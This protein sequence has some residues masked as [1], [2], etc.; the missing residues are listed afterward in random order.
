[1]IE[2]YG[3]YY[4]TEITTV[5]EALGRLFGFKGL[6]RRG[7]E[8]WLKCP[9]HAHGEERTPSA[10]FKLVGDDAGSFY[11]FGCKT[12][13]SFSSILSK[14][15]NSSKKAE[16]WLSENYKSLDIDEK[17]KVN[18]IAPE[19]PGVTQ[20]FDIPREY[21]SYHTDYFASR[22]IPDELVKKYRLMY[23]PRKNA[24][25]FPV[26]EGD[27]I[28]FYQVRYI[29]HEFGLKWYIPKN[30]KAKVFGKEFATGNVVYVCESC[31]N[32]L[33]LEKFGYSAVSMFGARY[34]ETKEELL[35]LPARK[36][37]IAYD[38]DEAG[39]LNAQLLC[40]FLKEKGRLAEKLRMPD[41]KD[42]NDFANLSQE[43]FD[44]KILEWRGRA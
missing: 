15:F 5:I 24:V 36:F 21:L 33:T 22:G 25:I 17:R 3:K 28:I 31:F 43:E 1:M 4:D 19:L 39:R 7:K 18:R 16:T 6:Q 12:R 26:W 10:S 23:S 34:D 41:K 32:A 44:K 20:V 40:K 13:G 9:W 8:Y 27:C 35:E 30:S 37:I 11:C 38:G 29:H 14:L 2:A 42:I